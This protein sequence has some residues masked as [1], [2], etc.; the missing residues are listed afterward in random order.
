MKY[1]KLIQD[2]ET[3]YLHGK[4]S[5]GSIYKKVLLNKILAEE[6]RARFIEN[7]G[8]ASA[9]IPGMWLYHLCL[10]HQIILGKEALLE[11]ASLWSEKFTFI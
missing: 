3:E 2:S 6:F 8:G 11:Y 9:A 4:E 5:F 10:L 7:K 1:D